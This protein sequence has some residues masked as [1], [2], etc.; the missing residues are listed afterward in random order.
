M[1]LKPFTPLHLRLEFGLWENRLMKRIRFTEEQIGGRASNE[2]VDEVEAD[3]VR[4]H[5]VLDSA[6]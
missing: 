3:V 1:H 2:K 6:Q 4:V 5:L